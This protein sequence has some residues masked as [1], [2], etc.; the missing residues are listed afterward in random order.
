MSATPLS[1]PTRTGTVLF[2]DIV[3]FTEFTDVRGD[4]AALEVLDCQ[5]A[6]ARAALAP[7][8]G[9]IVK[10]L[11][12]GLMVWFDDV[13]DGLR[14]AAEILR[15]TE[16]DRAGRGFPLALRMGMHRGDAIPRGDDFI[17]QTVNIASRIADL[18]GPGELL[19]SDQVLAGMPVVAPP[20]SFS[21]VGP[22]R[23]KGVS[24]PIWLHRLADCSER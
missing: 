7:T 24:Q 3:G 9:R 17:G 16:R 19:V 21:P 10:E 2:T 20:M 6:L 5:A 18:A 12:D 22:T 13:V 23:V 14:A 15:S 4:A 8:G 1:A 11:G